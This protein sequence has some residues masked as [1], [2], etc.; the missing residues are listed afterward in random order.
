RSST[1][2]A[3]VTRSE[4]GSVI[5]SGSS[6]IDIAAEPVPR[7][8][9]STGAGDLYAAGFLWGLCSGTS[10][11]DC[12][13]LGSIAAAEVIGHMGARPETPLRTL[14]AV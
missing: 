7:V 8:V 13:R 4:K 9:D 12:G 1:D 11:A 14:A 3:A 2:I 5:V 6:V 10:L